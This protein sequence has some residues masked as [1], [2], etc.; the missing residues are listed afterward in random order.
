MTYTVQRKP[1]GF[2]RQAFKGTGNHH[3]QIKYLN[4][5]VDHTSRWRDLAHVMY[6]RVYLPREDSDLVGFEQWIERLDSIVHSSDC[7]VVYVS[8][9][10]TGE[11]LSAALTHVS[12]SM[13]YGTVLSITASINVGGVSCNRLLLDAYNFVGALLGIK[14]YVRCA[15]KGRG[16][17]DLI[18]KELK[19]EA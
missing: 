18:Y 2:L 3:V 8:D 14:H 12:E 4:G 16:R 6:E 9:K 10:S 5:E 7:Y 13:H 15:Y 1:D 11:L 17:Y 19:W